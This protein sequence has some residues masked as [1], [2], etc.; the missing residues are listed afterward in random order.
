MSMYP[1]LN[2]G[3]FLFV[4]PSSA[5]LIG[6]AGVAETVADDPFAA[7]QRRFDHLRQM[8]A[9][10]SEHQQGFGFQMHCFMQ[11]Q[12][13]QFFTQRRTTGFAG[14]NDG[15]AALAQQFAHTGNM[16]ALARAVDS[17]K[18]NEPAAL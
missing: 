12:F 11:Q 16:R 10:G 18:S 7:C 17:F 1:L 5:T 6:V 9:P 3:E 13:T 14:G 2:E 8:F 4:Q 15:V